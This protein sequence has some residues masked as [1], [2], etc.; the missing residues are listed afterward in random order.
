MSVLVAF[1]VTPLG[2]GAS[3]GRVVAEAVRVVRDSGLSYRTDAMFTTVEGESVDEVMAVV[4][5]AVEVVAAQ[6][7]RVSAVVKMD[8]VP[9]RAEGLE[10][11]VA[12]VENYIAESQVE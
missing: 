7:P 6:S 9:G 3:V 8:Y 5:R 1:S 12:T 2:E 11:K 4:N 10:S